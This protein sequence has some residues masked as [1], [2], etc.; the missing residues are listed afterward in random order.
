MGLLAVRICGHVALWLS[1][2]KACPSAQ[3]S[4]PLGI[5]PLL[6]RILNA[7]G[8]SFRKAKTPVQIGFELYTLFM[9]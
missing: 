8:V 4:T 2:S 7:L 9:K 1:T 5:I 3:M 6:L